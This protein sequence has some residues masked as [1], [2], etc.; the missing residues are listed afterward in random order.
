VAVTYGY[1]ARE[2]LK[3]A[4]YLIDGM[5]DLL[6][7]L[8]GK[9]LLPERRRDYRHRI[10]EIYQ[11]YVSLKL[12]AGEGYVEAA[13][14][15][16]SEHGIKIISPFPLATGSLQGCLVSAPASLSR[17]VS[18]SVRIRHCIEHEGWFIAGARIEEVDDEVWFRVFTKIHDFIKQRVGEVF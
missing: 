15:D 6:P 8:Y 16:F 4:D 18:F 17:E 1:R 12:A 9:G 11:K 5:A 2:A 14:F 10:P 13:L 7:L 3:D